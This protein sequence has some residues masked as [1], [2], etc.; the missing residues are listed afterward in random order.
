MP[1][2]RNT[3]TQLSALVSPLHFLGAGSLDRL[4]TLGQYRRD[5]PRLV[6]W[7]GPDWS[8]DRPTGSSG[9]RQRCHQVERV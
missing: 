3:A 4:L 1:P 6:W 8:D 5:G 2:A 9:R 7:M